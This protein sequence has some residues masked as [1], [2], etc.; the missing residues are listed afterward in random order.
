MLWGDLVAIFQYLKRDYKQERNLLFTQVYS[1][2][3]KEKKSEI[4]IRCRG[5]IFQCDHGETLGWDAQRGQRMK[6]RHN[7]TELFGKL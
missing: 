7:E 5:E 2:M 6:K 3:T 1:D 4:Q